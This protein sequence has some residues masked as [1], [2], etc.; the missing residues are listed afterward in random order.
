MKIY[1]VSAKKIKYFT[2]PIVILIT[3]YKSL[4]DNDDQ[5]KDSVDNPVIVLGKVF[6]RFDIYSAVLINIIKTVLEAS[7]AKQKSFLKSVNG[8]LLF[9]EMVGKTKQAT[10]ASRISV[11]LER[12]GNNLRKSLSNDD[13]N[14]VG[15]IA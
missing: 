7:P 14:V 3:A 9:K 1:G 8:S 13:F 12:L 6:Y 5:S 2:T 4:R 10:T 15:K 11:V